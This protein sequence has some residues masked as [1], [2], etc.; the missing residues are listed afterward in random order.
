MEELDRFYSGGSLPDDFVAVAIRHLRDDQFH[1]GVTYRLGAE[2]DGQLLHLSWHREMCSED[3]DTD[4]YGVAVLWFDG[5]QIPRARIRAFA[6]LVRRVYRRCQNGEIP[7][8]FSLRSGIEQRTGDFVE[9]P[10]RAP[11]FTC[12]TF[13]LAVF[14]AAGFDLLGD[15]WP[16]RKQDQ[17]WQAHILDHLKRG[18]ASEDHIAGL[19]ELKGAIRYRPSEVAAGALKNAH[20]ANFR[21]VKKLAE[22]L[23]AIL[24]GAE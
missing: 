9:G 14:H 18:D 12:A 22:K 13:V 11:G 23:R 8:S 5:T 21:D 15:E 6:G 3:L 4:S 16:Q 1:C 24:R 10:D 7:Y 17:Q 19:E 2:E 20:P